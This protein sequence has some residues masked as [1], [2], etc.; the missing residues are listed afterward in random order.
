MEYLVSEFV[1]QEVI[2]HKEE[3]LQKSGLSIAEFNALLNAINEKLI[4]IPDEEIQHKEK[5]QDIM[6]PIDIKDSIFIAIA[7]STN[8]E[9]I[10][11]EDKHFEKQNIIKIWKTNDIMKHLGIEH[12]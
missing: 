5:A 1:F 6:E 8:N 9:G 11:S 2:K 3:I 12:L 7:L 4:L 10:W